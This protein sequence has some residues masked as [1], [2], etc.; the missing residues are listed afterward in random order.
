M[1]PVTV[2]AGLDLDHELYEAAEH[3]VS[4]HAVGQP[5]LRWED[6]RDPSRWWLV[7]GPEDDDQGVPLPYKAEFVLTQ[8]RDLTIK[9][10]RWFEADLRTGDEPRPHTHPWEVMEAYPLLGGYEDQHWHRTATGL[11]VERGTHFHQPGGLNRIFA[12]DYHM[13]TAI[14][15]PA[16][17]LSITVCGRWLRDDGGRGQWGHL[18]LCSGAHIPVQRDEAEQ[19]H[20]RQRLLQLNPQ[21]A[22]R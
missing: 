12:R 11:L 16:R 2:I 15:D 17:T 7:P 8:T 18:D 4:T 5:P 6:F 22:P 19:D 3:G 9:I 14:A 21:H 13:V 1:P 10:N 20:F